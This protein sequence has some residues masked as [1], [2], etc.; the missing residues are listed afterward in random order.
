MPFVVRNSI[1]FFAATLSACSIFGEDDTP[2]IPPL[3]EL[4]AA[5]ERVVIDGANLVLSTSMWRDFMPHAPPGGHPLIA[6]F[7]ISTADSSMFPEGV[8]SDAAFVVNAEQVWAAEYSRENPEL[9]QSPYRIVMIARD[10]PKWGPNVE[11]DAIV[12]LQDSGGSAY[13]LAARGQHIGATS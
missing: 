3:S 7:Y 9:D 1:L 13:L 5:P 6:I 11:V 10:G 4:R 2:D 8:A 12:R